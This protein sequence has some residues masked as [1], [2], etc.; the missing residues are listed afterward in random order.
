MHRKYYSIYVCLNVRRT[1]E[2]PYQK[3]GTDNMFVDTHPLMKLHPTTI[4]RIRRDKHNSIN[5]AS[6]RP[7]YLIS[8]PTNVLQL[9]GEGGG[10]SKF[11]PSPLPV[12]QGD[13]NFYALSYFLQN[14]IP[15]KFMIDDLPVKRCMQMTLAISAL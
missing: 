1:I 12:S 13:E 4:Y 2:A 7:S 14:V 3:T 11:V 6:P 5:N 15:E 9:W 8:L 10:G